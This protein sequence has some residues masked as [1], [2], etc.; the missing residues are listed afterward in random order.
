MFEVLNKSDD[1]LLKECE[2][3]TD[4]G[5]GPGGS[6]ADTSETAVSITHQSSDV[7]ARSSKTRSQH[8]NKEIALKKL[9]RAYALQVRHDVDPDSISLPP[10]L[11]EY[12]SNDLSINPDNRWYPFLVKLILDVFVQYDGQVSSTAEFL[13]V[14]TG[15][16]VKFFNRDQSLWKRVNELR[17][18]FGHRKLRS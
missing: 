18:E 16:L 12:V 11:D 4:R 10:S 8:K 1:E 3:H 15:K 9:R 14:S 2:V 13:D 5:A 6:K 17:E 7:T